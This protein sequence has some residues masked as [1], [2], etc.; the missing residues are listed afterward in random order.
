MNQKHYEENLLQ[1]RLNQLK[2]QRELLE[3]YVQ[4]VPTSNAQIKWMAEIVDKYKE[5]PK[6]NIK[7]NGKYD[8]QG[9]FIN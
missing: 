2:Q 9:N 1:Q 7:V 5:S 4:D 6:N 8:I 3:R